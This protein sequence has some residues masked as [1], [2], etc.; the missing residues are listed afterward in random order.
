MASLFSIPNG[1]TTIFFDLGGVLLEIDPGRTQKAL[2]ELLGGGDQVV[3]FDIH[4]QEALFLDFERGSL[5]PEDL[6]RGAMTHFGV[7]VADEAFDHAWNQVL[8]Q[9]FPWAHRAVQQAGSRYRTALLSNTNAIHY[10]A[11]RAAMQATFALMERLFL[12]Y[13]LGSRKPEPTIYQQA[14]AQMGVQ[15]SEVLFIEDNAENIATARQLGLH[16]LHLTQP[17]VLETLFG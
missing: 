2:T 1:V 13:E 9:P 7:A 17:Q 3:R 4:A 6:R 12:S 10:Q 11:F 5:S 14:L 15:P 16:T 8:L